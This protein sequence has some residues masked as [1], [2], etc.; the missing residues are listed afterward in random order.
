MSMEGITGL[1]VLSLAPI[2]AAADLPI[3]GYEKIG[4]V[5]L[6]I[7]AVVALWREGNKKQEKLERII[8]SNTRAM[9][10]VVDSGDATNKILVEVKEVLRDCH[11]RNGVIR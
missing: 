3:D 11:S 9:T 1:K 2:L 5:A 6:L 4:V 8:E 7:L 10:E